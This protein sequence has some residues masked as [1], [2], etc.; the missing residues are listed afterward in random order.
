MKFFRPAAI[1]LLTLLFTVSVMVEPAS[2]ID[3]SSVV[4]AWDPSPTLESRAIG[5]IVRRRP[6]G[7][8]D[9]CAERFNVGDWHV[10]HGLDR[11]VGHTILLC[12]DGS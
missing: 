8:S 2:A 9:S 11:A 12:C 4:L 5:S 10:F 7:F 1:A 6:D 3:G